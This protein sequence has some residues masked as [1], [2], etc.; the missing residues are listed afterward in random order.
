MSSKAKKID[1]AERNDSENNNANNVCGIIMPI[2]DT[3]TYPKGHWTDVYA[4]LCEAAENAGFEPNLVSFD[5]DVSVI[6]KRIVQNIYNNPIVVC[7]ISSRNANVMFELGMRLAF[8]KPTVIVKDEKTPYSFDISSIEHLEYPSDLRYQSINE[9]KKKLAGKISETHKRAVTDQ[10]YT[11]FLKHFGT[12]KVAKLDEKEVGPN[13]ILLEEIKEVKRSLNSIVKNERHPVYTTRW[14]SPYEPSRLIRSESN[15][16][17]NFQYMFS[18]PNLGD[19][20]D[21]F[22]GIVEKFNQMYGMGLVNIN[23]INGDMA[24]ASYEQP[25]DEKLFNTLNSEVAAYFA[26][27]GS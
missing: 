26:G 21:E 2:A 25:V 3:Q 10:D 6:Q 5:D 22:T 18:E 19:R 8:D 7:D 23:K 13:E 4:I 11:T 14:I 27:A 15:S 20:L 16:N 17:K 9:F 1:G 24:T 12:F